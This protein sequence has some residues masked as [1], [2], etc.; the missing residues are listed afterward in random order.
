MRIIIRYFFRTLRLILTPIVLLVEKLT[1]PK[2]QNRSDEAQ[3]QVDEACKSLA[4][5]QF[6]ACPFCVK[7]R[8]EIARLNLNIELRDAKNNEQHRQ[9][10]LD[11]GGRVKV[12]CLRIEQDDKV[13]W[14]Y[15]SDDINQYLQQRFA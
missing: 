12:P 13:Q 6:A 10:L 8:K 1:T 3:Q 14:M 15:E 5:Y 4:L 2:G 11:G 9:E 7:V